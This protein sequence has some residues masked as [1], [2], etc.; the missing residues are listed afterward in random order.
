MVQCILL[1]I[2]TIGHMQVYCYTTILQAAQLTLCAYL[3]VLSVSA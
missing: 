2:I 1:L 3:S